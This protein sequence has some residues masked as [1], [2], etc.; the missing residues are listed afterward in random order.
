MSVPETCAEKRFIYWCDLL[1]VR[2]EGVEK[3][4]C[5]SI[6]F[7]LFLFLCPFFQMCPHHRHR[8]R[9][10]FH[11][12]ITDGAVYAVVHPNPGFWLTTSVFNAKFASA[13]ASW[14]SPTHFQWTLKSH[15]I[16]TLTR[17]RINEL[18]WIVS[19]T[20]RISTRTFAKMSN[21]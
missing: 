18:S 12:V 21:H 3:S 14:M 13:V 15:P 11:D 7:K 1:V 20:L 16:A 17:T 5:G 10:H 6:E 2:K 8:S 9:I 19:R 4:N